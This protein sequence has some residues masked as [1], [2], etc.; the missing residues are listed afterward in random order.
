[1]DARLQLRVQRYGWDRASQHYERFWA[2]QLAP[3]RAALLDLAAL[4]PGESVLDV[5][6]GT[7]L[8]TFPAANNV[9]RTGK[10]TGTDLC[11]FPKRGDET[12]FHDARLRD[13]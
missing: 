8:V 10:V 2:N 1:M 3:A 5:A 12:D 7:G 6:C 9:G 11:R 4:A 13:G